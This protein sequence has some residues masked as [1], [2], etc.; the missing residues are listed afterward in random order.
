M[1]AVA[2]A[3]NGRLAPQEPEAQEEVDQVAQAHLRALTV[4]LIQA[5]VAVVP[6]IFP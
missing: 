1:V 5:V 3:A 4:C 2:E 6:G